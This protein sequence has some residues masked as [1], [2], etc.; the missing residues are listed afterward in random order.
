MIGGFCGLLEAETEL[1]ELISKF[2]DSQD[3]RVRAQSFNS[4]LTMGKRGV[5]LS[6]KLYGRVAAALKDD[7]ECVRKEAL[8]LIY[9]IGTQHS[10]M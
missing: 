5:K 7:Y 2:T 10:E 8:P 9:E 4:I 3:A 1:L 6:P